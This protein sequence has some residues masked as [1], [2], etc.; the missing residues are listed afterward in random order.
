[1]TREEIGKLLKIAY[2]A[3]PNA[4]ITDPEGML[5]VWEMA[6]GDYPA[7]KIY[8]AVR[9]HIQTNRFFPTPAD[10]TEKITRA[11]IVYNAPESLQMRLEGKKSQITLPAKRE[12]TESEWEDFLRFVGFGYPSDLDY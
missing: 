1:M 7:D 5:N 9:L 6:F 3:Y 2:A 8:K 11:E 12:Y 4:K 10:I